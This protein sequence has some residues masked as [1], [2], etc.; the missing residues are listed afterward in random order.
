MIRRGLFTV[1]DKLSILKGY[2]INASLGKKNNSET[3]MNSKYC[4]FIQFAEVREHGVAY[5]QFSKD[6]AERKSQMET[7][8]QLREQV[9]QN[10][11]S[12]FYVL[13]YILL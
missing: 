11:Y 5:Y 1:W 3:I 9:S 2:W 4:I 8:N 13:L 7:L 10:Y 12:K 6:E